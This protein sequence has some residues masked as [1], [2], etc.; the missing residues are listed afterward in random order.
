M[1]CSALKSFSQEG[2]VTCHMRQWPFT[3][4]GFGRER[5]Q[6][7]I[8]SACLK[9][10]LPSRSDFVFTFTLDCE[11]WEEEGLGLGLIEERTEWWSLGCKGPGFSWHKLVHFKWCS[12]TTLVKFDS[13]ADWYN[14]SERGPT[15]NSGRTATPTSRGL[16]A[17]E[18]RDRSEV[19]IGMM[20]DSKWT[21]NRFFGN[22]HRMGVRNEMLFDGYRSKY[23][24]VG[25]KFKVHDLQE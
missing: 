23:L 11:F 19:S 1:S 9:S 20:E 13:M 18:Q 17:R 15:R 7:T 8:S 4:N 22:T 14:G 6:S 25:S 2:E 21:T 3:F 10:Y 16:Q 5:A 24:L 12:T